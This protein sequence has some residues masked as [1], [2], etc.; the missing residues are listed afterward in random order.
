MLMQTRFDSLGCTSGKEGYVALCVS[1]LNAQTVSFRMDPEH[2][3]T[4]SRI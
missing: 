2:K 3:V 1:K 4:N